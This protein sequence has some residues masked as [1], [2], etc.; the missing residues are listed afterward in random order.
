M[1]GPWYFPQ[2]TCIYTPILHIYS[3]SGLFGHWWQCASCEYL[4]IVSAD[5]LPSFL[6][7][8][9]SS[10]FLLHTLFSNTAGRKLRLWAS[11]WWGGRGE[12]GGG[13]C[14]LR[15]G[16]TKEGHIA[17][18]EPKTSPDD[19]WQQSCCSPLLALNEPRPLTAPPR[20]RSLHSYPPCLIN[21]YWH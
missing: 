7:S 4:R 3:T 10:P 20:I 21:W 8:S 1:T 15:P 13:G 11:C 5:R 17:I 6:P 9:F 18:V 14:P 2:Y 19:S 12:L 16:H